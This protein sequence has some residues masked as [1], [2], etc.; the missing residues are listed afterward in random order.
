MKKE[1]TYFNIEESYGWNQNWFKDPTMK[2]GGCAAVV[3]CDLCIYLKK[4][5]FYKDVN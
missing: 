3:S 5:L 4:E 2:L 1:L